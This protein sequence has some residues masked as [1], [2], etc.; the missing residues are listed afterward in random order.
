MSSINISS[1]NVSGNC[2][3]KCAYSFDYQNSSTTAKNLG[4]SINLSYDTS[5]IPP[6]VF[7]ANKYNVDTV[8]LVAPSIHSFNGSP[9][10][11]ELIISHKPVVSGEPFSVGIPIMESGSS[12]DGSNMLKQIITTTAANAPAQGES[13]NLNISNFNLNS[14]V[15]AKKPLYSFTDTNSS[16][17]W[18]IFGQESSIPLSKDTLATL[19][20]ILK[21][22]QPQTYSSAPAV[23]INSAG[24]N[25]GLGKDQIY[26]DC[27]PV[28]TSDDSIEVTNNV[29]K[30]DITFDLNNPTTI[31]IIQVFVSCILFVVLLFGIQYGLKYISNLNVTLPKMGKT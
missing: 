9:M 4:I 28:T 23:F 15:P 18:I 14:F 8:M 29:A 16:T 6:V 3:L 27:Q 7:N 31:L 10:A 13:T 19:N 25:Q 26:I 1:Q 24:A 21:P 12:T 17:N 20:S 5:N 30:S 2:N 22:S 11:A